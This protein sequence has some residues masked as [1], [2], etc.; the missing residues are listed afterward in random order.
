M[1]KHLV[2]V[3]G[4]LK[5]G[6]YNHDILGDSSFVHQTATKDLFVM[7]DLG[8]F[9]A[10]VRNPKGSK[11]KGELYMVDDETLKWLDKL[12]GHPSLYT[13]KVLP[14][15]CGKSAFIYEYNPDGYDT[16]FVTPVNGYLEWNDVIK[17]L[18]F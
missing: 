3:Y 12:E 9:P 7:Y 13:R 4:S 8:S 15:D 1:K 14:L 10:I 2:F 11:V 18:A 16:E 5:S 17:K 6:F